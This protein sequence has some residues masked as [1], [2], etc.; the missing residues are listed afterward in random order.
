MPT[1]VPTV[2]P[3]KTRPKGGGGSVSDVF[4]NEIGRS[5]RECDW[6]RLPS[7]P[8]LT[9]PTRNNPSARTRR[10]RL[11]LFHIPSISN[12][13]GFDETTRATKRAWL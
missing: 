1:P 3:S 6:A 2:P 4:G 10:L 5:M 8:L 9:I 12:G 7:G 13:N 11:P